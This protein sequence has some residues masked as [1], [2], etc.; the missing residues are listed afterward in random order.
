MNSLY[1]WI[2]FIHV[3]A[4][5]TFIMGHGVSVALAFRIQKE[6]DLARVQAMFDLS[7]SMWQIYMLSWLV[8]MVAGI[9][10]GFMGHWWSKGW[11]WVSLVLML[12]VTV[13]MFQLGMKTYHPLRKA[14]GL[15]YHIGKEEFPPE[16]PL[17]EG[18]RVNLLA[19]TNPML[20]IW[21]GYGGFILILWLM[22][23]KP[24]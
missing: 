5:F 22:I 8:L 18:E 13:W 2:K 7:G 23:F 6:K 24:F 4:G 9:V 3:V 15:A 20:M 12:V 19:A 16:T 11:I 10:N 1:L 21:V 14:F 17:S